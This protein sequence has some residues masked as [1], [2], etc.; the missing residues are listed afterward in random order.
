MQAAN[1]YIFK[2]K[3][4]VPGKPIDEVRRE[5][6]L[7]SVIK[8]ASNENPYPPSPKVLA[9]MARAA[10]EVNRYPDGG[11][12]ILRRGLARKFNVDDD[13]L[14]FGNG[15]D[16]IICLAV[17]A[18]AAK[19]GEVIIAKPSFLVYEIASILSGA[20]LHQVP[21]Q[22]FR[23][24]LQAM[25]AKVNGRT[26]IIFI[27]NPDNPAGTY[28]T[29][30]QAE[31]FLR[32][33]PKNI[34][35]FFDEAYFEYV[36]A[37]DYPDTLGLMKKYP[38][39]MV[40]RTFSKMYGLAGLRIGY[41]IARRDIIDILNRLREPFNVNSMAQAAAAAVLADEPYYRKIAQ[42]IHA[43]RLYLYRSLK[44]M[45]IAFEESF[46]NFILVRAGAD[47]SVIADALLNK[48]VIVRDMAVWGLKG[49]I[50]TSIGTPAENKRFIKTLGEIL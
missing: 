26:R 38:N 17:R 21:L 37:D 44:A 9:A 3:P 4:Y 25:R 11:C 7:K 14:L 16:E 12:F 28:I 40:A 13:Q 6:G 20:R 15:S 41:G 23:Y 46:T 43:Q 1:P 49:Y 24:D 10:R 2:T 29:Q 30:R 27:G 5:L 42:E 45:N 47:S 32:S 18:F 50:R 39:L 22:S 36:H 34:L 35:V 48:G 8:L 31:D 19:G 33:V